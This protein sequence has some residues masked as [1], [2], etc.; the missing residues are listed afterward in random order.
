MRFITAGIIVSSVLS[1]SVAFASEG[2][3]EK[4]GP[5]PGS[6]TSQPSGGTGAEGGEATR[7]GE[8][9]GGEVEDASE[10]G[11][12]NP[13]KID[14]FAKSNKAWEVGL[15]FTTHRLIIQN[16]LDSG[17]PGAP[18]SGVG[19]DK[20]VNDYEGYV[21]Y[22]I[23]KHDRVSVRM[24][25]YER[26][27]ADPGENGIRLDDM[28]F[29][30]T[31]SFSLPRKF[32][33]DVGFLL[34][35][36][37]SYESYLAGTVTTPRLSVGVDRRFGA[38]SLDARASIQYDIQTEESYGDGA[39]GSPTSLFHA[40]IVADAELH[41]PFYEPLSFGI[42][43]AT[44]YTWYH[45]IAGQAQAVADSQFPTQPVQQNYGGEAYVRY[46]MPSLMGFK[47]DLTLAYGM[48]D[49]SIGY[50]NILHDGVGHLYL[51]Y[52]ENSDVYLRLAVAY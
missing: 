19:A 23:T 1:A 24:Y 10:E 7:V 4:G 44:G 6:N 42:G 16:D 3:T 27:L 45:N 15:A 32:N 33:L 40:N 35:A 28:V 5:G 47:P 46:L 13:D 39:G 9:G 43:A 29:T 26:F 17:G 8:Q 12:V 22:D 14:P 11:A 36:P 51:A 48:G 50:S 49:S 37:T 34:T 41:L 52:R 2:K 38:L 25:M 30:Y 18:S 20:M 31:H 21:R